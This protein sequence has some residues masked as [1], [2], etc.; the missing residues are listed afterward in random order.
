MKKGFRILL[1]FSCLVLFF[2]CKTEF[3]KIR[4]SGDPKLLLDTANKYFDEEEYQ[5]AQTLYELIIPVYRG[6]KELEDIYY[7]YAYTYYYLESYILAAYYFDNFGQTFGASPRREEI[8]FMSAYA[9]YQLSPTFRLDQK[10]TLTAIDK[11]QTFINTYTTSDK[12]DQ[13]NKLIDQLR[14]KLER[15]AFESGKLYYE[16]RQY[17]SALQSLENLLKDFPETKRVAEV[18]Y[19]I[20]LATFEYAEN[21]I[22]DKQEA[23]YRSAV[24]LSDKFI[25]KNADSELINEVRTIRKKAEIKLDNIKNDDRYKVQGSVY[26]S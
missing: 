1:V 19:Y 8:D 16:L 18:R 7:K 4:T 24:E 13:A 2:S 14:Q 26:R 6:Q 11:L 15:K 22:I 3:E 12:V 21:S 23:R 9:N 10:Y 20:I 25:E 5:K 17:A